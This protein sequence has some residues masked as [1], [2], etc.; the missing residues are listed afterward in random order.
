MQVIDERTVFGIGSGYFMLTGKKDGVDISSG[1]YT[2]TPVFF[3]LEYALNPHFTLLVN[4]KPYRVAKTKLDDG[5]ET[6]FE[7]YLKGGS[8][9][10][11][12][13]F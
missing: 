2:F 7:E 1:S 8:V 9:Q 12:Y 3:A 6:K 10:L 5:T 11:S 4:F 13:I